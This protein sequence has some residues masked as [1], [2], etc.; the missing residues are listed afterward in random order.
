MPG[1]SRRPPEAIAK[2]FL[3]FENQSDQSLTVVR[4][5]SE[6]A[7][8]VQGT[9]LAADGPSRSLY[10]SGFVV[11]AHQRLQMRPD[12]PHLVVSGL[13]ARSARRG[14]LPLVLHCP[15]V[16]PS[17]SLSSCARRAADGSFRSIPP[18][19]PTTPMNR[20]TLLLAL[21]LAA[22]CGGNA[23][24]PATDAAAAST[25][26][27]LRPPRRRLPPTRAHPRLRWV[28]LAH[29]P[30]RMPEAS[31]AR[32]SMPSVPPAISRPVRGCPVPSRRSRVRPH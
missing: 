29:P 27:P 6:L 17:P 26:P 8:A 12:G 13:C 22:A 19:Q 25:P 32:P 16:L 9:D 7:R 20:P 1:C 15:T 4:A 5:T 11:A 2:L 28:K 18:T 23:D 14:P 3:H 31:M 24:K 10:S 21:L 30:S